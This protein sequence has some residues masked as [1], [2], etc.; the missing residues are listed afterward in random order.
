MVIGSSMSSN[1]MC[2]DFGSL[3][4]TTF[5]HGYISSSK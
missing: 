2:F 5:H 3:C 1:T 4:N